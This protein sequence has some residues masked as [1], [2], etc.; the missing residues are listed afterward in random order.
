MIKLY[1]FTYKFDYSQVLI[2]NGV[3]DTASLKCFPKEVQAYLQN[4]QNPV[5]P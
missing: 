1:L 4:K 3:Q 2:L 5:F